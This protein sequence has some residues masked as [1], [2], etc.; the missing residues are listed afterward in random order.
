[1][2]TIEMEK[3]HHKCASVTFGNE[4]MG[5]F[6]M[7]GVEIQLEKWLLGISVPLTQMNGGD[8]TRGRAQDKVKQ[9]R[10]AYS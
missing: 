2:M 10:K 5:C 3:L 8:L 7:K 4:S 6:S 1:M 9:R